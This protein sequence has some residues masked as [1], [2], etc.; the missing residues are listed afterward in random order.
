MKQCAKLDVTCLECDLEKRRVH[1]MYSSAYNLTHQ[2][3]FLT[4][5]F[6]PFRAEMTFSSSIPKAS[7]RRTNTV[8]VF[9]LWRKR[10]M[11]C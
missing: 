3:P 4:V 10:E 5:S 11:T 8:N 2:F 9:G 7:L 6:R 1:A